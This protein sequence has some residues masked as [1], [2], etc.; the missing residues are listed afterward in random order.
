VELFAGT[1][2]QNIAR[3][4]PS[5]DA[6]TVIAAARAAGLHDLIVDLHNGYDMQIGEGGASLSAGQ[7]QRLALARALYGDPFLVVLDEP[8]SN[9]DSLGEAALARALLH[10]RQQRIT[11]VTIT[12]RPALLNVVD[13]IMVLS[14]GSVSMFGSRTEVMAALQQ[15]SDAK[16]GGNLGNAAPRGKE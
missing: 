14:Q 11:V 1:V 13:K 15:R 5:A 10:A 7:R 2:A 16:T 9:L 4:E 3:F 8:N 12:Q 6:N